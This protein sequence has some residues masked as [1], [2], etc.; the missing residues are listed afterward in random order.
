MKYAVKFKH[1]D[2]IEYY[3]LSIEKGRANATSN[4]SKAMLF[5]KER[6]SAYAKQLNGSIEAQETRL[7][8][9]KG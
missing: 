3:I 1:Y 6:A 7:I 5:T 9:A 4:K 2:D 8:I